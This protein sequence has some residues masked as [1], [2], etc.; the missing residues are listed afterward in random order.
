M[1]KCEKHD[2]CGSTIQIEEILN[3]YFNAF[4]EV[5]TK[6]LSS[7]IH[8]AAHFYSH[9]ENGNLEDIDKDTFVE[10]ISS[11]SPNSEILGFVRCDEILAIDLISNDVAVAR[12]RLCFNTSVCTDIINLIRLDGEWSIISVLDSRV[13]RGS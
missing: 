10:I 5:D 13:P 12:V 1:N 6:E 9:D 8:E 11:F 4:Y 2:H 3:R 7:L